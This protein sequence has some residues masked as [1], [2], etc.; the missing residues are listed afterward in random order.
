MDGGAKTRVSL[1]KRTSLV[2]LGELTPGSLPTFSPL[3]NIIR[4]WER[5][6]F[7][8]VSFS[9]LQAQWGWSVNYDQLG[10]TSFLICDHCSASSRAAW[11]K[12]AQCQ[13]IPAAVSA[14]VS[15]PCAARTQGHLCGYLLKPKMNGL[16][17]PPCLVSKVEKILLQP[18]SPTF[19][20]LISSSISIVSYLSNKLTS[21]PV[22]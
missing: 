18:M 10:S 5:A 20:P 14:S 1:Q 17:F 4:D 12:R 8:N 2:I 15:T 9:L 7:I 13:K 6:A 21:T 3:T 16:C 11:E 22:F 19:P